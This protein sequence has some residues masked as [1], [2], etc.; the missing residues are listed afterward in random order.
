MRKPFATMAL[1][2]ATVVIFGLST[3]ALAKGKVHGWSG[4]HR[5]ITSSRHGERL[6]RHHA[7]IPPGWSHGR[8]TG[9]G[10]GHMPPGLRRH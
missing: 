3:A 7:H 9:W 10:G 4:H 1:I 6:G 2:A 8:K 5:A